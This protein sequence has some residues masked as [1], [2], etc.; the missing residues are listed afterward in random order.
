[1][2]ILIVASLGLRNAALVAVS[3]PGSFLVGI[4]VLAML[5]MTMNMVTMFA[6]II[7]VGI[8]VDGAIIVV[9]YADRKMAEGMTAREAYSIA[10]QRMFWPV[11]CSIG[12]TLVAFVPL[13]FWPGT[14]GQM[15][16]YMPVTLVAV[17]AASI[18][19]ALLYVP[20]MGAVLGGARGGGGGQSEA[21]RFNLAIAETGNLEQLTRL[22]G[23]YYRF[24]KGALRHPGRVVASICGILVLLFVLF[25]LFNPGV[26]MMPRTDPSY[27]S[28]DIRARG[29]LSPIEKDALVR[30]AES[31]LVGMPDVKF[32]YAKTGAGGGG[33][34]GQQSDQIGT[35]QLI[36]VDWRDRRNSVD[37]LVE[38]ARRRV[39][40]LPGAVAEVRRTEGMAAGGKRPIDILVV[41]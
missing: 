37:A 17:L 7:S 9:E 10:A 28:V 22:T 41:A 25:E 11:V 31:R 16:R 21:N 19:M 38:E 32:H 26:D 18:V 39:A 34:A 8:V 36:F 27:I 35:I 40:N 12:A 15:M 30:A 4:L 13:A 6:L 29:D 5:D 24:R 3:I 33:R 14:T 2:V 20:V 23:R 1:M